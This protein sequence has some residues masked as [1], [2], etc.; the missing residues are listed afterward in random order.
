[1]NETAKH[2]IFQGDVQG[3]GF[4]FTAY[5]IARRYDVTGFVRNLPDGTVQMHVQ[6]PTPDVDGC[7]GDL[8][9]TMA[10]YIRQAKIDEVPCNP[11]HVEF[12]IT[13]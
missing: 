5:N 9:E 13:F 10:G 2:I 1:M 11:Q 7:L 3:V 8:Q 4:R 12:R 6:G